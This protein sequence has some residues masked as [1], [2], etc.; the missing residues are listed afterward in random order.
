MRRKAIS[1]VYIVSSINVVC[2]F[3]V[4]RILDVNFVFMS[5]PLLWIKVLISRTSSKFV[6]DIII[7]KVDYHVSDERKNIKKQIKFD[8]FQVSHWYLFE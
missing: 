7:F 6:V 2:F 3:V 4:Y 1:H 8:I 5:V